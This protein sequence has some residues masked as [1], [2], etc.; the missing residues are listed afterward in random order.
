MKK[1]KLLKKLL[2]GSKNIRFAEASALA[3]SFGFKLDRVSGSHHIYI[4]PHIPDLINLQN[5]E[6]KA[7]PYQI[8]QLLKIIEQYDLHLED[9][10]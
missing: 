10:E 5:I 6:G 7:K 1:R 3:E 9:D 4:H 8:K 2:A